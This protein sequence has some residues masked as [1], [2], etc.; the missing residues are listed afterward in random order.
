MQ[1]FVFAWTTSLFRIRRLEQ[2]A[3]MTGDSSRGVMSM[4]P[5]RVTG[6]KGLQWHSKWVAERVVRLR[7]A[8][9]IISLTGTG[10]RAW[11]LQVA[12]MSHRKTPFSMVPGR[13]LLLSAT[14]ATLRSDSRDSRPLE[15]IAGFVG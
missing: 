9:S 1:Q 4:S 12:F 3:L 8:L 15:C 7:R 10:N 11:A 6:H 13:G 14:R 2:L 5:R